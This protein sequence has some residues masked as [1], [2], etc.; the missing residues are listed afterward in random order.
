[1]CSVCCRPT[2]SRCSEC[3]FCVVCSPKCEQSY[4]GRPGGTA[5]CLYH[6]TTLGVERA[7]ALMG[8]T[9]A[10]PTVNA[11][12][13]ALH[14]LFARLAV[15]PN[16]PLTTKSVVGAV[17]TQIDDATFCMGMMRGSVVPL[18]HTKKEDMDDYMAGGYKD[19]WARLGTL[20][21]AQALACMKHRPQRRQ[22]AIL[23]GRV[24]YRPGRVHGFEYMLQIDKMAFDDVC[25]NPSAFYKSHRDACTRPTT[26]AP[27]YGVYFAQ[28][29]TETTHPAG[30]MT[31]E[32]CPRATLVGRM[33]GEQPAVPREV[34]ERAL[35]VRR[36][37]PQPPPSDPSRRWASTPTPTAPSAAP[38][39]MAS[40]SA[41]LAP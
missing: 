31:F 16:D 32:C 40:P 35:N 2:R 7:Q 25:V 19:F 39:C 33:H 23:F 8:P 34:V 26:D 36:P 18:P 37:G 3:G 14:F 15:D 41:V 4:T 20:G 28:K 24:V 38:V 21:E 1:M 11:T 12:T 22:Q 6:A 10:G 29:V 9:C 13:Q 30:V 27:Y 17:V 5:A